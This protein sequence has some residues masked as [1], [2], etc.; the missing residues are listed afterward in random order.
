MVMNALQELRHASRQLARRPGYLAVAVLTLA[1]GIG[2]NVA[3]FTVVNAIILKPLPYPEPDRI[4]EVRHHTPGLNMPEVQSSPGLIAQYRRNARSLQSVA[5]YNGR[6][7]NLVDG[8]APERVRAVAVSADLFDVLGTR[9]ANGRPFYETDALNTAPPVTILSHGLWQSRFGGDP[10]VVGRT[11]RLDGEATEVVGIMPPEFHFPDADTRLLVPLAIDPQSGFGR[12]GMPSLARLAPGVTLGVARTEIEQLQQRIPEWFPGMTMDLLA[13]FGWSVSVSRMGDRVVSE[14]SRTLWILFAAVGFVLVI[15][16][17][18]VANLF[19]V[20]AESRQRELAL[21]A[22][23]GATRFRLALIFLAESLV[24]AIVGGAAGL[25][26]ASWATR[27]LIA[28]GPAHL[29][30]LQEVRLDLTVVGFAIVLSLVTALVLGLL[31]TLSL[32]RRSFATTMRDGGRGATVGR[33]RHRLRRML[34]VTQV[35]MALVLLVGSGLMLKSAARLNAIDP[36]F[37]AEGVTTAGVS[38][39]RQPDRASAVRFYYQVLDQMAGIPGVTAVGAT[40]S[41]PVAATSLGGSSFAV[42]SRPAPRQGLPRF[43]LYSAVTDGYFETLKVSVLEGR[44]PTRSD[45]EMDRPVVWV[46]RTFA[47]QFLD[48]RAVGESIQLEERWL[49]IVGT[50]EDVRVFGLREEARAMAYVPIS[51]ASVGLDVM[52]AVVRTDG[53]SSTAASALRQAVDRVDPSVPLT[54]V[55]TMDQVLAAS[56][57][58]TSFTTTLLAIAAALALLLGLVGLYGVISYIVAQRTGEIGIR[59]AL[60][61]DPADVSGM[62][63]RQGLTVTAVGIGVG[64]VAA[65]AA[66]RLMASLLFEVSSRDPAIFAGVAVAL[67]AVSAAATYLPARRAA[68]ID[69]LN[70]LRQEG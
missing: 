32:A 42:R 47:R 67:T 68:S 17:A 62:V 12:L 69:P 19:L 61:A 50:V 54:T 1:L 59:L 60:G 70:A 55:R 13:G 49:E 39:G 31:P 4:V 18:N 43:T 41:L 23:L 52:Y 10:G 53:E 56:L 2:A 48:G 26:I 40:S 66:T 9:P 51:N 14:V 64:L 63:L 15:A 34:I 25:M 6:Q 37:S 11:I 30:R 8:G 58:Q 33:T 5:G 57:A 28:Y 27:L 20:R 22:A 36:G 21:R 29:P 3:I 35:A 45:A 38:L 46:S 65:F 44:A 16:A 7:L 24:L